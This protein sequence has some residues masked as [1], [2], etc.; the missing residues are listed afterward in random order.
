MATRIANADVSTRAISL[1]AISSRSLLLIGLALFAWVYVIDYRPD[2]LTEWRTYIGVDSDAPY[3]YRVLSSAFIVG[4]ASVRGEPST[5]MIY[6]A[7][8]VGHL[9]GALALVFTADRWLRVWL[10]W[11]A[12]SF[13]AALL[14]HALYQSG[15]RSHNKG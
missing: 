13:V 5:H 15:K 9:I 7:S 12:C 14:I 8:L 2:A 3:R 10:L 1:P 6:Y 4:L 11:M